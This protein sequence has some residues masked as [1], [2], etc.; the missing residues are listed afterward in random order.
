MRDQGTVRLWKAVKDPGGRRPMSEYIFPILTAPSGKLLSSKKI[1][2]ATS[3]SGVIQYR[4]NVPD[5]DSPPRLERRSLR[6]CSIS[7]SSSPPLPPGQQR[8][9]DLLGYMY[10]L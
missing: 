9:W 8:R 4:I 3:L 6:T 5:S 10:V 1:L 2:P 7:I